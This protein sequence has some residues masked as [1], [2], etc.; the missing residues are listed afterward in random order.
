[1]GEGRLREERLREIKKRGKERERE[2]NIEKGREKESER[3][4]GDKKIEFGGRFEDR[5]RR[6]GERG[7]RRESRKL[8]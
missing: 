6:D 4:K 5:G 1:M 2:R 3:L 7:L 8:R